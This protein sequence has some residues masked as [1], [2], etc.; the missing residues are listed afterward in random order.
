MATGSL[1][2]PQPQ[3]EARRWN[4][5]GDRDGAR[6]WNSPVGRRQHKMCLPVGQLHPGTLA[7]NGLG[8]DTAA[9]VLQNP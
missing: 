5:Q 6:R 7:V 2:I 1:A 3:P 9:A 8:G 4:T